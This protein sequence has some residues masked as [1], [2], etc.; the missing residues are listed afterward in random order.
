M[1]AEMGNIRVPNMKSG[2]TP[3]PRTITKDAPSAAPADT[4]INPGSAKGFLNRP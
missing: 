4:P 3:E 2:R 1:I